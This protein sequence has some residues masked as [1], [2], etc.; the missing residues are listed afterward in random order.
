MFADWHDARQVTIPPA[1]I[2]LGAG[3]NLL[4]DFSMKRL[5]KRATGKRT[6]LYLPY[7][8]CLVGK[9]YKVHGRSREFT[10]LPENDV[11]SSLH[12]RTCDVTQ[13]NKLT[14]LSFALRGGESPYLHTL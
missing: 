12:F 14:G 7:G 11:S 1:P 9:F 5:L 3:G 10:F 4:G 8:L 13:V 2:P 6:Y